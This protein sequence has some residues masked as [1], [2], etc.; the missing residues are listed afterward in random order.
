MYERALEMSRGAAVCEL[1]NEDLESGVLSYRTAVYMLEAILDVDEFRGRD[2]DAKSEGGGAI[3]GLELED[4]E[5]V[6]RCKFS[7]PF[8]CNH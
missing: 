3:N 7:L 8:Y 2:S 5:T 6:G 4:R 1:T